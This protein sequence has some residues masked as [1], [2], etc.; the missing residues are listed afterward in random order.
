M[1]AADLDDA[2]AFSAAIQEFLVSRIH[3]SGR[4]DGGCESRLLESGLALGLLRHSRYQHAYSKLARYCANAVS[5]ARDPDHGSALATAVPAL[6]ARAALGHP[7]PASAVGEVRALAASYRH[8]SRDRKRAL[9]DCM[10]ASVGLLDWGRVPPPRASGHTHRWVSLLLGSFEVLR[11]AALGDPVPPVDTLAGAL[12][13]AQ[14]ADGSWDQHVLVTI[15]VLLSLTA[16][17]A[18]EQAI[19]R[20]LRFLVRQQRQDGGLPFISSEDTW[21]TCLGSASLAESGLDPARFAHSIRYLR[22]QQRADGGWAYAELVEQSDTDDTAVSLS[23]LSR[24]GALGEP[25][26]RRAVGYLLDIQNPDGGFPTFVRGSGSEA[27]ITAKCLVAL[28]DADPGLT[29]QDTVKSW[30]WLRSVQDE[31]GGF[32]V[33]WNACDTFPVFH[34]VEAIH[35]Y[36]ID[37]PENRSLLLRCVEFLLRLREPGGGW[38]LSRDSGAGAHPLST[39]Y[40]LAALARCGPDS[41][42]PWVRSEGAAFL[43]T[44]RR[45]LLAG[46][47][48]PDSL[49]PRPFPYSVPLLTPIYTLMA[50]TRLRATRRG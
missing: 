25:A 41:C 46:E 30:E 19:D 9:I 23:L 44:C 26:I 14:S 50:L 45:E 4:W 13:D 34:V 15:F 11:S 2:S 47:V 17:G 5:A 6:V 49:G 39:A 16:A 35:R 40:A 21:V 38:P 10:L 3:P 31:D 33:Q 43:L 7:T 18:P 20:G 8:E 37:S 28:R 12:V 1:R 24:T 29:V 48:V 42:P 36:G 22:G 32:A 27:E